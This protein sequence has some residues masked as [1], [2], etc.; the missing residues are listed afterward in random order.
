L[1]CEKPRKSQKLTHPRGHRRRK[2]GYK[3][4][5][6]KKKKVRVSAKRPGGSDR[7]QSLV[8][9]K[10]RHAQ[11]GGGEGLKGGV[12]RGL[13]AGD[14]TQ[15]KNEYETSPRRR[16][17]KTKIELEMMGTRTGGWRDSYLSISTNHRSSNGQGE[18]KDG[19]K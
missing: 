6:K 1:P 12:A 10:Q 7:M 16:G 8:S 15:K 11:G 14:N 18:R 5:R 9:P 13:R 4:K 19:R 3:W 17:G 2:R